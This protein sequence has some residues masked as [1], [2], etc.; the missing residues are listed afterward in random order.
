MKI[1]SGYARLDFCR[2]VEYK[3][4]GA[5]IRSILDYFSKEHAK[6]NLQDLL[7]HVM[8]WGIDT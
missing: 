1:G 8:N 6:E 4:H 2:R 3:Q 5:M 7:M